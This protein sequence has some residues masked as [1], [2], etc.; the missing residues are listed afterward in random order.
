V[1]TR[2]VGMAVAGIGLVLLALSLLADA[3]G[4]GNGGF[5]SR[6]IVGAVV[7]AL[8]LAAGLAL[9]YVPRRGE[10]EPGPER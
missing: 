2:R 9:V 7:G 5:G 10:V 3:L 1:N 4:F 6:Q 8:F